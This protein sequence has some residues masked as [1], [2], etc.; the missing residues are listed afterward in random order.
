MVE[1]LL[2]LGW[3]AA[4]QGSRHRFAGVPHYAM[5]VVLALLLVLLIKSPPDVD[6][7][8]LP[9]IALTI[10]LSLIIEVIAVATDKAD[11]LNRL[12]DD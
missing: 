1:A 10:L 2:V 5:A 4:R 8:P 3:L 11:L 7:P 12:G 6:V 9:T